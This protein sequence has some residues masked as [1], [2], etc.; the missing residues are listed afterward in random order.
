MEEENLNNQEDSKKEVNADEISS[1]L[2]RFDDIKLNM[3]VVIGKIYMPIQSFLKI[4][5]GTIIE[6][7]KS[8]S[9]TMEIFVNEEK[10]GDC[11]IVIEGESVLAEVT[12]IKRKNKIG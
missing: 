11:D 7:G 12:K 3:K 4:T 5:R 2:Q 10:I 8:R 6:I 1:G 9:E